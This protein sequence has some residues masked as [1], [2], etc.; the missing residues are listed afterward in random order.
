[1][2]LSRE[3]RQVLGFYDGSR[4]FVG[5]STVQIDLTDACNQRCEVCWI[6]ADDVR[7]QRPERAQRAATLPYD[8]VM[9]LLDEL[10]H[11]ET[12]ELYFAGGGEP[13]AHP[14][15][16][17]VLSQAVRRGFEVTL[18]TNLSLAGDDGVQRILDAGIH[19]LCVS[20]WAGDAETY[21]RT[22][23]GGRHEVF[24]QVSAQLRSLRERRIDRPRIKTYHVLTAHN[25]EPGRVQ[26]MW[27]HA[28]GIGIDS[29]EFAV[30]DVIPGA[31][32]HLALSSAQALALLPVVNGWC[33]RARW[34]R[35]ALLGGEALAQRL[36]A[37]AEGK[38][39]D[40]AIV[41][42]LPCHAGWTY[43]RVLADG[44]VIP[45]LKAHRIPS[46]DLGAAS[47]EQIWHGAAQERFRQETRARQ[48]RGLFFT[49]IGNDPGAQC[50][51]E[52]GCDNLA[53]NRLADERARAFGPAG[54][55]L[56]TLA[57]RVP[58]LTNP[59]SVRTE[60]GT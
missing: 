58:A 49:Q 55:L 30:A 15:A 38:P 34:R 5:P 23:P 42:R 27:D 22:H 52:L 11:L 2:K 40:S 17:E 7:A 13:L 33:T 50:G 51:C 45:C 21:A 24:E 1:M 29:V 9:A 53:D 59:A 28:E 54:R 3:H 20:L 56:A 8:R 57:R 39:A 44:R 10:H 43:A 41:H 14:R 47:F 6:H 19:H 37:L 46:G 32:D 36:A 26:A 60:S 48:K 25:G 18:H 31:T 35:P 12:K 16:W 4:A